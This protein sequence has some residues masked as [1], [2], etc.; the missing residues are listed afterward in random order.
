[1][2]LGPLDQPGPMVLTAEPPLQPSLSD[3]NNGVLCNNNR[4]GHSSVL[5]LLSDFLSFI[6]FHLLLFPKYGCI[7]KNG[8]SIKKEY[9][10]SILCVIN[11]KNTSQ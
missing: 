8:E 6:F 5:S 4:K 2:N 1:M 11:E 9:D 7:K 10:F 3:L